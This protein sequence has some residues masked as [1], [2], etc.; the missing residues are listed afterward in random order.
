MNMF[1]AKALPRLT[2]E[3]RDKQ[4]LVALFLINLISKAGVFLGGS[5]VDD[6]YY[7][8]VGGDG[9]VSTFLSQG[10]F[11]QALISQVLE[12]TG[13]NSPALYLFFGLL[14]IALH[15]CLVFS[16]LRFL[17]LERE[18][19]ALMVG[20]LILSHPYGTE[21]YTFKM[22]LPTYCAAVLF[23]IISI[24]MIGT[25]CA[26]KASLI[27]A[28]S[29]MSLMLF[30]YQILLNH[31]TVLA[32][33][34]WII[35]GLVRRDM[36]QVR[37]AELLDSRIKHLFVAIICSII[38]FGL[39]LASVKILGV[40]V[41]TTDG[42]TQLL[43]AS[44]IPERV[45]QLVIQ[46][47]RSFLLAEPVFPGWG[48]VLILVLLSISLLNLGLQ[49]VRCG[50]SPMR[51]ALG[52]VAVAL[53]LLLMSVGMILPFRGWWPVPRVLTHVAVIIGLTM[54]M[55][56]LVYR[57]RASPIT[58]GIQFGGR[59]I[60]IICFVIVSN[61]IFVDQ[62]RINAWDRALAVRL[63]SQLEQQ[64]GYGDAKFLH[65]DGGSAAHPIGV[66]TAQGDMNISAFLPPWS[67]VALINVSL[68]TRFLRATGERES[69]GAAYC[70]EHSPWPAP[71]SVVVQED[72]G[73]I[74]LKK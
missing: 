46:L 1:S 11:I 26:G 42:R 67:K 51:M 18:P 35:V 63:I 37:G 29:A 28:I 16:S 13:G 4:L 68:G 7:F 53:V 9:N 38:C 44:M 41:D 52:G 45:A 55:G 58:R 15:A 3:T 17:G 61:Q 27:F 36:V 19:T 56:D 72:V 40:V 54:L 22:S 57:S 71:G 12:A 20:A 24:E 49:L 43:T 48:K 60:L 31:I 66:R 8:S 25:R 34:G 30:T 62:I 2:F 69:R 39:V 5:S 32:I 70:A 64:P 59:F 21:I 23:T 33:F 14:A 47:K 65:V 50:A 6:Y 74:C 10:R 73:T